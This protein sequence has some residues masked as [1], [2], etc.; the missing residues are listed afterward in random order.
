VSFRFLSTT[1][2]ET[3]TTI[4]SIPVNNIVDNLSW[5]KGKHTIQIGANWRLIHQNYNSDTTTWQSASSNPFWLG[6]SPPVPTDSN[7][8]SLVPSSFANSYEI[9]FANLVG[10]IPS[11][12]NSYNVSV[13]ANP[14]LTTADVSRPRLQ[15]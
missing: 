1:T 8:N 13:R 10:T 12:T 14:R 5:T 4:V 11:L 9:A 2:A 6:G 15:E 7:G 3:R